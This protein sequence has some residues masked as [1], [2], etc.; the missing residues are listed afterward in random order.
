MRSVNCS[1]AIADS[2][3]FRPVAET[4]RDT[5]AWKGTG[6]E[7][8]VGL[9]PEQERRLLQEWPKQEDMLPS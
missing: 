1:K 4:V 5:L 8:K 6:E 7:L 3:T 2:L 9:E